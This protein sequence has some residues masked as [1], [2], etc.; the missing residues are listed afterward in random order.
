MCNA[1][2][3]VVNALV[4]ISIRSPIRRLCTC[5]N[6]SILF[7]LLNYFTEEGQLYS[8]AL[9]VLTGSWN[10]LAC[11]FLDFFCFYALL[12]RRR[13]FNSW[14]YARK[15]FTPVWIRATFLDGSSLIRFTHSRA[16]WLWAPRAQRARPPICVPVDYIERHF[17]FFL[18]SIWRVCVCAHFMRARVILLNFPSLWFKGC[19]RT[20]CHYVADGGPA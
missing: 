11:G 10:S 2:Y 15:C 13:L 4:C 5:C 12:P 14:Q 16:Q 6:V 1:C 19:S 8:L 7:V 17:F 9:F 18:F 3:C 20:L